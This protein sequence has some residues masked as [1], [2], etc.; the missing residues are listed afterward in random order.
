MEGAEEFS[1]AGSGRLEFAELVGRLRLTQRE[2]SRLLATRGVRSRSAVLP[3]PSDLSG[4]RTRTVL[5][6]LAATLGIVGDDELV[7]AWLRH[8]QPQRGGRSPLEEAA[9]ARNTTALE[10]VLRVDPAELVLVMS[11]LDRAQP[12]SAVAHP[13]AELW[14]AA[15]GHSPHAATS[16]GHI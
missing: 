8:P 13:R 5:G 10:F 9:A 16:E 1:V 3:I 11:S 6:S 2:V 14:A 4:D 12:P 15:G 7:G